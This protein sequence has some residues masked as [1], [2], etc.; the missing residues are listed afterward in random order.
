MSS[1]KEREMITPKK[2]LITVW[3]LVVG[4][5]VWFPANLLTAHSETNRSV[6]P[7]AT[8]TIYY[9]T[10]AIFQKEE[11]IYSSPFVSFTYFIKTLPKYTVVRCAVSVLDENHGKVTYFEVF[12]GAGVNSQSRLAGFVPSGSL[13]F[14]EREEAETFLKLDNAD[15]GAELQRYI[16][17]NREDLTSQAVSIKLGQGPAALVAPSYLSELPFYDAKNLL[18][19]EKGREILVRGSF[20]F[21]THGEPATTWSYISVVS[22]GREEFGFIGTEY[23]HL[24]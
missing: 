22:D 8:D 16:T 23:Y 12:E 7:V 20:K 24:K 15:Q 21:A 17:M 13:V 18:N 11:H 10:Y 4:L 2:R 6:V 9:E 5:C 3:L 19:I 1:T 14:C